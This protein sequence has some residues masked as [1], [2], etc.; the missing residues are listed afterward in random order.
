MIKSPDKK[1][2]N[3]HIKI[4]IKNFANVLSD[5]V[6]TYILIQVKS[7]WRI[8]LKDINDFKHLIPEL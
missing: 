6:F 4:Q 8:Q 5:N 3:V 1:L 7:K 2:V